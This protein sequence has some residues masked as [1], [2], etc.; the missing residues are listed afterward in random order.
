MHVALV[1]ALCR[2]ASAFIF[3]SRSLP[4]Y[5]ASTISTISRGEVKINVP[6]Y[7]IKLD[8]LTLIPC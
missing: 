1:F 5:I 6:C 7:M 2:I 4:P 8:L 3:A